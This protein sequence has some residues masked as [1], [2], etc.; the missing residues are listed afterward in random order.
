MKTVPKGIS[1][2]LAG[3]LPV[4]SVMI[5]SLPALKNPYVFENIASQCLLFDFISAFSLL[6]PISAIMPMVA[7]KM[8]CTMVPIWGLSQAS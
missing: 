5:V 7:P 8:T 6:N 4:R 1:V 3:H 2:T